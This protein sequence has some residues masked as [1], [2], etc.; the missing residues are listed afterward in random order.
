MGKISH[1][2]PGGDRGA[3]KKGG[4]PEVQK[5]KSPG[6]A[7]DR[8]DKKK[9]HSKSLSEIEDI[10]ESIRE[11]DQSFERI[12]ADPRQDSMGDSQL[13]SLVH[14]L[15]SKVSDFK[16]KISALRKFFQ[17][18]EGLASVAGDDIVD[19]LTTKQQML[20]SYCANLLFYLSM[21]VDG[22]SVKDH[23]VLE[24]LLR[25]R[26]A[27]EKMRAVDGKIKHQ[28]ERLVSSQAQVRPAGAG[29]AFEGEDKQPVLL[30]S[31]SSLRP[32]PLAL[33]GGD[34]GSGSD[35]GGGD[36][37]RASG[38]EE[39]EEE[40]EDQVDQRSKRNKSKKSAARD[41]GEDDVQDR[42]QGLYRP[43]RMEAMPFMDADGK[44]E[45]EAERLKRKRQK[46]R[47]SEIFETLREEFSTAPEVSASGGIAGLSQ[48]GKKLQAEADER[49]NFE[50]DRFVRLTMS[51]KDKKDISRRTKDMSDFTKIGSFG[52][53][54]DFD[55][56]I[57]M[58]DQEG[59][60]SERKDSSRSR[61]PPSKSKGRDSASASASASAGAGDSKQMRKLGNA[62]NSSA[63]IERAAMTFSKFEGADTGKVSGKSKKAK[64]A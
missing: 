34:S 38:D 21:R 30:A 22:S 3:R 46:L 56:I 47:S 17:E 12:A 58:Y 61:D 32:N 11:A 51:R 35:G 2:S 45:K 33:L 64:R 60:K 14:S 6:K 20:L 23:P 52:G 41:G 28:I 5:K 42:R 4:T 24:Q 8:S 49:Q 18:Q 10:A 19:Y 39:D 31:N 7:S 36:D 48:E 63:A 29:A 27:L 26:F 16:E 62:V 44:A 59:G 43:P 57:N 53:I 9:M 13:R 37:S 54:E 55:E 15:E 1:Q 40:E 50:E 25:L